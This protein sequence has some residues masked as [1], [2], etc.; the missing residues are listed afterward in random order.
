MGLKFDLVDGALVRTLIVRLAPNINFLAISM[1]HIVG[2]G[3]SSSILMR[4]LEAVYKAL[5]SGHAPD[6]PPVPFQYI[7]YA[8]WEAAQVRAGLFDRQLAYWTKKLAHAPAV[9]ALPT[10]R[11][12]P[13]VRS[14]RGS[15][16]DCRIE[17]D[18]VQRLQQFSLQHETTLFM[19]ILAAWAVVLHRLSGQDDVVIG[20]PVANRSNPDL[21][22]IVG[23]F[24]NSLALRLDLAAN[25][26]FARFLEQVRRTT[27]EAIDN[28]RVAF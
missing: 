5:A 9:L 26:N 11:P 19:T 14:F 21:E 27:I 25:P 3:W 8:A 28:C 2:D 16:F 23:P 24:V 4:E 1:H 15:R 6:L 7:D 20:T 22:R 18:L 12:R 10:D 13:P 17:S